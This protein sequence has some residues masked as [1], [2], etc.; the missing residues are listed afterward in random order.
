MEIM[1]MIMRIVFSLSIYCLTE[2]EEVMHRTVPRVVYLFPL[3]ICL[4]VVGYKYIY[5]NF[6]STQIFL[7]FEI[8]VERSLD[9]ST[10]TR[11][12]T[13]VHCYSVQP[14]L[15]SAPFMTL[16]CAC[17]SSFALFLRI[18]FYAFSYVYSCPLSLLLFVRGLL[19]WNCQEKW[20]IEK[21][22]PSKKN[23]NE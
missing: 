11:V 4:C 15:F 6:T 12:L 22:S 13:H 5:H 21:T 9:F 10:M 16:I 19:M 14:P 23:I 18:F 1:M 8:W 2:I 7:C 3:F 17:L 20:R